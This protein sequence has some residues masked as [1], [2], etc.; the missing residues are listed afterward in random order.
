MFRLVFLGVFAAFLASALPACAQQEWGNPQPLDRLLPQIRERH[1]G[2]FYDAEGPYS[3]ENGGMH[4]R[5]KWMTPEGRIIWLDT[6]ARTGRVLGVDRGGFRANNF[7]APP[8][9]AYPP[10][11]VERR[12]ERFP[13]DR[14]P[15][16]QFGNRKQY[17]N[18]WQNREGWNREHHGPGF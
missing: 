5:L 11:D 13:N 10:P 16:G 8:R 6:D 7:A 15:R 14:V 9:D 12:F 3:D 17:E 4:Y 2:T 18:H 1:P